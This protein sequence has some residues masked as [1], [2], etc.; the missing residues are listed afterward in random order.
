MYKEKIKMIKQDDVG[1]FTKNICYN[2]NC[3]GYK[4]RYLSVY[5]S[6]Y[7]GCSKQKHLTGDFLQSSGVSACRWKVDFKVKGLYLRLIFA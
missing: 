1:W 4:G 5:P 7:R 3:S 6:V 2:I